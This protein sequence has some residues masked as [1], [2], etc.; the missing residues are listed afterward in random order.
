MGANYQVTT[1]CTVNKGTD[2]MQYS[3]L[4]ASRC[5]IRIFFKAAEQQTKRS[6]ATWIRVVLIPPFVSLS[7]LQRDRMNRRTNEQFKQYPTHVWVVLILYFRQS[8]RGIERTVNQSQ[9][10]RLWF[11]FLYL[12]LCQN[13]RRIERTVNQYQYLLSDGSLSCICIFVKAADGQN[14]QSTSISTCVQ[15]FL[16]AVSISSSKQQSHRTN[17]KRKERSISIGTCVRVVLFLYP[18]VRQSNRGVDL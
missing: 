18:Y 13:N 9:Y 8:S 16:L 17:S 12:Y 5:S 4:G 6:N 10:L 7:N 15:M 14:K 3:R 11:S 2:Q 1:E